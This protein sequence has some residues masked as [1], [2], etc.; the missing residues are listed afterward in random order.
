MNALSL[1][2]AIIALGF[3]IAIH[4]AGHMLVGKWCGMRVLRY[5]IGFGRPIWST[6]RGDTTYQLC[7]IPF[8]G[9]VV[10]DQIIPGEDHENPDD[11]KLFDNR[12]V[13]A[14]MAAV[15]AGPATNYLFAFLLGAVLF[16]ALGSPKVAE[17]P[18]SVT[19]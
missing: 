14:R 2:L 3:L 4:E 1:P 7:W 8:G 5:S 19:R 16:G 13:W 15:F 11:P 9:Y 12:P 10:F 6:T 17:G 18:G